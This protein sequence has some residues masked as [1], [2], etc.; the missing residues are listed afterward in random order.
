MAGGVLTIGD[1]GDDVRRWQQYLVSQ[2]YRVATDGRFGPATLAATRQ[3]QRKLGVTPDGRVGHRT[4]A[5]QDQTQATPLPVA[6][7]DMPPAP[8][9]ASTDVLSGGGQTGDQPFVSSGPE[10]DLN[11]MHSAASNNAWDQQMAQS[12]MGQY[13]DTRAADL[14]NQGPPPPVQPTFTDQATAS[15]PGL[16]MAGKRA[17]G[18]NPNFDA[19]GQAGGAPM[20]VQRD[21]MIRMLLQQAGGTGG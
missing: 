20:P 10:A 12:L 16:L 18:V 17:Q 15:M 8:A 19:A 3:V 14:A 1:T 21:Q 4:V 11:A 6:R 7:P 2:G 9:P 13:Y 5:R